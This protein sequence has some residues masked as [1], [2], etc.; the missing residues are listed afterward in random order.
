VCRPET[1]LMPQSTT[2]KD[3]TTRPQ[4]TTSDEK[5]DEQTCGKPQAGP[6]EHQ[7]TQMKSA[8]M[9]SCSLPQHGGRPQATPMCVS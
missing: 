4:K 9:M 2:E 3:S 7:D 1:L 5:T 8:A 6:M